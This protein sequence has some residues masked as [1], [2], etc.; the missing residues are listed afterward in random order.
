MNLDGAG[1]RPVLTGGRGNLYPSWADDRRLVALRRVGLSSFM[2]EVD[3]ETGRMTERVAMPGVD[4]VPAPRA[5]RRHV[6]RDGW[7][8]GE[9]ARARVAESRHVRAVDGAGPLCV[10]GLVARRPAARRGDEAGP[11]HADGRRRRRHRAVRQ[12]SP[13][14]G[15]HWPGSFSPDGQRLAV[16]SPGR[17]A[18]GTSRS[19]T[20]PPASAG[21]SPPPPRRNSSRG[22]RPGRRAATPSCGPRRS[23]PARCRW[24]G[25]RPADPRRKSP[26]AGRLPAVTVSSH[27]P[28]A[29]RRASSRHG[30]A[31]GSIVRPWRIDRRGSDGWARR[32]S[33]GSFPLRRSPVT[34]ESP[35]PASAVAC[36]RCRPASGLTRGH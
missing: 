21:S 8:A 14:E 2:V 4:V 18:S 16:A 25:R 6:R 10:P 7:R 28:R 26:R 1:D 15:Q 32:R 34:P 33:R 23:S 3:L 12:I 36:G 11:P 20:S 24:C 19:S 35:S 30:R 31:S 27:E 5:R 22:S 17:P 13:P 9:H 29:R